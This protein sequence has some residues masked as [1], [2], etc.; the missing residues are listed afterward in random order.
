MIIIDFSVSTNGANVVIIIGFS[1]FSI[2]SNVVI[3]GSSVSESESSVDVGRGRRRRYILANIAPDRFAWFDRTWPVEGKLESDL[4][5]ARHVLMWAGRTA[6]RLQMVC[7]ERDIVEMAS[8][9]LDRLDIACSGLNRLD[10]DCS[11][12]DRLDNACSELISHLSTV[13]PD[14]SC[15][16]L[17][18]PLTV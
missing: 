18:S 17:V 13:S 14:I 10:M 7:S 15:S 3:A 2:G 6:V 4:C 16:R 12:L 8:S 5:Q 9:G 11:G 1:V